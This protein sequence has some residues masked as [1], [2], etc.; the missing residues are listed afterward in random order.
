MP[1]SCCAV[2]CTNRREGRNK[3][4][5]F[6]IIPSKRTALGRRR[7]KERMQALDERTEE[8]G[9]RK[10]YQDNKYAENISYQVIISQF[11]VS[12]CFL[13]H[14]HVNLLY[15]LEYRV[16]NKRP[17]RLLIFSNCFQPPIAIPTSLILQSENLNSVPLESVPCSA[18]QITNRVQN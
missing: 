15:T 2:S 10:R 6:Y 3:H 13:K 1:D 18:Q 17:S 4:L 9:Q 7:R 16:P 5:Q 12:V 8:R 14:L 11:I